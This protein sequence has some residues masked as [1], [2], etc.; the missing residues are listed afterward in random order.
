MEFKSIFKNVKTLP[1][2]VPG[3]AL[4]PGQSSHSVSLAK[5]G[6]KAC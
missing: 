3:G 6:K 4:I 2:E 5:G 1:P